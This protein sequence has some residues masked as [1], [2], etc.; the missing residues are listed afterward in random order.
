VP[1]AGLA[2]SLAAFA[3]SAAPEKPTFANDVAP[4]LF[5]HCVTCHRPGEAAPMSFTNYQ[6][7]RP[8]AKAIRDQVVARSMPV[9]L[10]DPHSG[11][12]KN[13]R[14]LSQVEIDTI[15]NWVSTG[16]PEGDPK[17]M[18]SLPS[19]RQGLQIHHHLS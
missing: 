4:I 9:W 18:P 3:A 1:V 7:V 16:A 6:L 12:F 8:W 10:A 17:R 19:P 13:D 5:D 14:R 15:A 11:T 2:F